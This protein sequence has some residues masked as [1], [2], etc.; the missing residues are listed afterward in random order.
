MAFD[1]FLLFLRLECFMILSFSWP[2]V[3][4]VVSMVDFHRR[5][6]GSNPGHGGKMS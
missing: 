1:V 6:R 2:M 5:D 3:C 4:V